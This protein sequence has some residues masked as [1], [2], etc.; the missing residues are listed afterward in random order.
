MRRAYGQPVWRCRFLSAEPGQLG[1]PALEVYVNNRFLQEAWA[2]E[3]GLKLSDTGPSRVVLRRGV[4]PWLVRD[5]SAW[6]SD[7]AS[8]DRAVSARRRADAFADR[9]SD[10]VLDVDAKPLPVARRADCFAFGGRHRLESLRSHALVV[11]EFRRAVSVGRTAGRAVSARVRPVVLERLEESDGRSDEP[12]IDVSFVGSLSPHHPGRHAWLERLCRE[13]PI[14]VWGQGIE[15]L[16]ADSP[17]RKRLSR[18]RL[19]H[20]DVSPAGSFPDFSQLPH[21]ARRILR[22][23]HAPVRNDG[24]RHAPVDRLE[25]KPARAVRAGRRKWSAIER[26]TNAS[27]PSTTCRARARTRPDR[28]SRPRP[29]SARAHLCRPNGRTSGRSCNS[30]CE[31]DPIGA[32]SV[33]AARSAPPRPSPRDSIGWSGSDPAFR[34]PGWPPHLRG[35]QRTFDSVKCF[36]A[37]AEHAEISKLIDDVIV[38]AGGRLGVVHDQVFGFR[39]LEIHPGPKKSAELRRLRP[40][41]RL[42]CSHRSGDSRTIPSPRRSL[43]WGRRRRAAARPTSRRPGCGTDPP[44]SRRHSPPAATSRR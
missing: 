32:D 30:C 9:S 8:A 15:T 41:A 21:R 3:H 31:F 23:Q 7:S 40:A 20:R 33:G 16:A 35:R 27:K 10:H 44:A 17:I 22:Q 18:A 12:P 37:S 6:M 34:D 5:R 2:R 4:V 36:H 1:H 25:A 11:A 39:P 13:V 24:R 14:Q 29:H 28:Q 19:G 42:A 38:L 26:P 43:R